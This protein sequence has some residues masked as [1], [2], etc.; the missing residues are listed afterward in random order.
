VILADGDV[1]QYHDSIDAPGTPAEAASIAQLS[2]SALEKGLSIE[3]YIEEFVRRYEGS[4][5][6]S[7]LAAMLGIGR[8]ALWVRR[9]RWGLKRASG[10][11]S[12]RGASPDSRPL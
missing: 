8:K 1:L 12:R 4:Y 11:V 7:Q 9:G 2:D 10:R 5:S 3:Q 6:D